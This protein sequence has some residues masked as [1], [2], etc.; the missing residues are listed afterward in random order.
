MNT[1]EDIDV[2]KILEIKTREEEVERKYEPVMIDSILET[3]NLLLKS[4]YTREELGSD[5]EKELEMLKEI[6][7]QRYKKFIEENADILI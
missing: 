7:I 2:F 4:G 1:S 5:F 6:S 3:Y